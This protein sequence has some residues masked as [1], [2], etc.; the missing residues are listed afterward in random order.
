MGII[1]RLDR[2]DRKTNVKYT[3][4]TEGV[5]T[6]WKRKKAWPLFCCTS[7]VKLL[8]GSTLDTIF[9][10]MFGFLELSVIMHFSLVVIFSTYP[11]IYISLCFFW[12]AALRTRIKRLLFYEHMCMENDVITYILLKRTKKKNCCW[13]IWVRKNKTFKLGHCAR[14]EKNRVWKHYLTAQPS[15]KYKANKRFKYSVLKIYVE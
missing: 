1:V 15:Y 12:C 7:Y 11:K 2:P 10:K 6:G 3:T 5:C 9:T 14:I 13:T 4:L 8:Y